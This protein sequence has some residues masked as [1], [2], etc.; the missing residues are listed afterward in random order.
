MTTSS[1]A[2][3]AGEIVAGDLHDFVYKSWCGYRYLLLFV[4]V[5]SRRDFP[6]YLRSK[7]EAPVFYKMVMRRVRSK[8]GRWPRVIFTDDENVL[9]SAEIRAADDELGVRHK[10]SARYRHDQNGIVERSIGTIVPSTGAS[11]GTAQ[12]GMGAWRFAC[13][14]VVKAKRLRPHRGINSTPE[15]R[16]SGKATS[17]EA[18]SCVRPR[19]L[20]PTLYQGQVG[21]PTK[22]TGV[23]LNIWRCEQKLRC[24]CPLWLVEGPKAAD[25]SRHCGRRL[26]A[27]SYIQHG[28][29]SSS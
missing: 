12:L 23:V 4:D 25:S 18:T 13:D 19:L 2:T 16:W 6:F 26:A 21:S 10:K 17:G 9:N 11:L 29:A 8:T 24:G 15:I 3:Y 1:D 20:R 5:H 14:T 7:D 22:A 27:W 28:C